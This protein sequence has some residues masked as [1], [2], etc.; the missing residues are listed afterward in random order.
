MSTHTGGTGSDTKQPVYR[1]SD[2]KKILAILLLMGAFFATTPAFG[3]PELTVPV[4]EA[5][6]PKVAVTSHLSASN[7]YLAFGAG[8]KL[9][10]DPVIQADISFN[11]DNGIYI[12]L[13]GST[14]LDGNY[15]KTKSGALD[16]GD[17]IDLG[18]GWSGQVE[19]L[20]VDI[21]TTYFDEPM[22][23]SFGA[24]DVLYT[25]LRV[26][27]TFKCGYTLTGVWENYWAMPN[28][29]L[30]GGNLVGL[31]VSKTYKLSEKLSAPIM[32][33]AVYDDGGF[34]AGTGILIRGAASLSYQ[35]N[36]SLSLDGGCRWYIPTMD[37]YRDDDAVFWTG[38]TYKF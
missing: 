2:M 25:H 32:I 36:D 12:L 18:V 11:F 31:E 30:G 3:T 28:S 27:K 4:A 34:G 23:G 24:N 5:S 35:I 17:E 8:I 16:F 33:G 9:S 22:P 19:G 7:K 37:D 15:G 26:G 29:S 14:S 6:E 21:G 10:P 13:W 38:I 20:S 1:H